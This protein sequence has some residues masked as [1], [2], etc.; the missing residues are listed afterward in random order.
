MK[1]LQ[2]TT[3]TSIII[4]GAFIFLLCVLYFVF[5]NSSARSRLSSPPKETYDIYGDNTHNKNTNIWYGLNATGGYRDYGREYG[6]R[7]SPGRVYNSGAY[8][9]H[10]DQSHTNGGCANH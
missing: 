3:C 1:G 4:A 6:G 10:K 2:V 7:F 9:A 5:Y 8:G